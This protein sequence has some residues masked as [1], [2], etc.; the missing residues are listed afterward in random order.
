MRR[1]RRV[2]AATATREP[3]HF[4]TGRNTP[5]TWG[6]WYTPRPNHAPAPPWPTSIPPFSFLF[7]ITPHTRPPP[8]FRNLLRSLPRPKSTHSTT[9]NHSCHYIF[10][11]ERRKTGRNGFGFPPPPPLLVLLTFLLVFHSFYSLY[12]LP[13]SLSYFLF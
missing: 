11:V 4:T 12:D 3:L 7:P 5:S 13:S 1:R 2:S 8:P 10:F 9:F 6:Q